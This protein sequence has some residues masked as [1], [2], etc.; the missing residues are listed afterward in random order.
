MIFT[1]G[2]STFLRLPKEYLVWVLA[3]LHNTS[4]ASWC[5]GFSLY[6][7]TGGFQKQEIGFLFALSFSIELKI[8]FTFW[9]RLEQHKKSAG[10]KRQNA[11]CCTIGRHMY[12]WQSWLV[13]QRGM[14]CKEWQELQVWQGV[15]DTD[16]Q[17]PRW[18]LEQ[19][20]PHRG[21]YVR[22]RKILLPLSSHLQ[23]LAGHPSLLN[24]W[25]KSLKLVLRNISVSRLGLSKPR[26]IK[27]SSFQ[28]S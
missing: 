27:I 11:L 24:L 18:C 13:L 6:R 1:A 19:P 16:P 28:S 5:A 17:N 22:K 3:C 23:G 8:S 2:G 25:G 14:F 10:R 12:L 9:R 4:K 26:A 15:V 21:C 20:L 7:A